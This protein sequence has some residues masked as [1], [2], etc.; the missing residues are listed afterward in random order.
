MKGVRKKEEK[1][2]THLHAQAHVVAVGEIDGV[3]HVTKDTELVSAGIERAGCTA[4]VRRGVV[5][6]AD[7]HFEWAARRTDGGFALG[8]GAAGSIH[9]RRVVRIQRN[10][11]VVGLGHNVAGTRGQVGRDARVSLASEDVA[12]HGV[13]VL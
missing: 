3:E 12:R 1:Q 13:R 4:L 10:V 2:T 6:L 5:V 11:K 8:L 9:S 7:A